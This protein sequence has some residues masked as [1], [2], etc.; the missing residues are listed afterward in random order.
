MKLSVIVVNYK[1]PEL[2][3][4][5]LLRLFEF[6]V[7]SQ[8]ILVDNSQDLQKINDKT[9]KSLR[10]ISNSANIGFGRAV[11]QATNYVETDWFLVINP[12]VRFQENDLNQLLSAA[13]KYQSPL[14]GPRF[15]WDDQRQFRLP[16]ATGNSLWQNMA[17]QCAA[18][19]PLDARLLSFYWQ[20]R[21]DRFWQASE[22]FY[23]PF[24]SGACLL[25]NSHWLAST[26]GQLFDD[27]FFLYFEDTDL[28]ARACLAGQVPLCVPGAEF[29]HYYNQSPATDHEKL[30]M[31]SASESLFLNKYYDK[32]PV[33]DLIQTRDDQGWEDLG[34]VE[35]SP[36]FTF[37]DKSET[38]PRGSEFF[39]E[40]STN[41]FFYPFA[42]AEF[43]G[44]KMVLPYHIWQQLPPAAYYARL[45]S[46]QLS[47]GKRWKWIKS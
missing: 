12:D 2:V 42:Q 15:Y 19:Y 8:I 40:I 11:N 18:A 13:V 17:R 26:G 47:T 33:L 23:E 27:R 21:H 43:K 41:P 44:N 16:P 38:D 14:A 7:I 4:E 36:T 34:S 24:L 37:S 32:L 5:L 31:I 22:P 29:I 25:V 35:Q 39:F 10:L 1:T 3:K 9:T 20:L 46:P 30:E 45:R 28:C 6:S